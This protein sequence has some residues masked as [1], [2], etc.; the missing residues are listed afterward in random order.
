MVFKDLDVARVKL[1]HYS[2]IFFK[3]NVTHA[4]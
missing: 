4:F 1:T 2:A 3:L